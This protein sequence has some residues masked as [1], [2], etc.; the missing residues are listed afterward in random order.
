MPGKIG[1]TLS[2]TVRSKHF[3]AFRAVRSKHFSAF[4]AV[5]SKHFSAF[6]ARKR[7]EHYL[8]GDETVQS[9]QT[10]LIGLIEN[11]TRYQIYKCRRGDIRD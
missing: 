11:D 5:R 1:W 8:E 3:S 2:K 4:R 9:P 7:L 10:P 6:R